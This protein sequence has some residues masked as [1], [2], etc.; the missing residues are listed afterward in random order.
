[1]Y[2]RCSYPNSVF[3]KSLK[4]G[5][6]RG[7]AILRQKIGK[8]P[9]QIEK[10]VYFVRLCAIQFSWI[11]YGKDKDRLGSAKRYIEST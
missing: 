4:R 3:F 6:R 9:Y 7:F 10:D 8:M 2:M 11:V 1:M 5:Y